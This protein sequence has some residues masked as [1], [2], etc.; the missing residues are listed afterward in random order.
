MVRSPS[1]ALRGIARLHVEIGPLGIEGLAGQEL[2]ISAK[3]ALKVVRP[4]R[5][6]FCGLA[7]RRDRRL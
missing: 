6:E 7:L 3:D 5:D 4:N 2:G 1:A